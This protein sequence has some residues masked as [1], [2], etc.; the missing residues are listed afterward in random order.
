[1]NIRYQLILILLTPVF[2]WLTLR[3]YFHH[4]DSR[5]LWQR[6]FALKLPTSNHN[7]WFHCASVGEVMTL[8][9]LI[10]VY[11][12][13]FPDHRFLVTTATI[14]GART[15]ENKLP[16]VTHCY[17]PLDYRGNIKRFI[18]A[19]NP[20]SLIIMETE[21]WPN[22]YE[23]SASN[24][25]PIAIINGRLSSRTTESVPW[26]KRI[27]FRALQHVEHIYCRSEEDKKA[28]QQLGAKAHQ[29]EVIGNLKFSARFSS[30]A[31]DDIINIPYV[32]AASTRD[33]EEKRIVELWNKSDHGDL[34]LVIAPRHPE[35]KPQ[36]LDELKHFNENIKVRSLNQEIT[37]DT[38]IYLADTL[39]E[40]P[41]LFSHAA[42]VIMGGSFVNRGGHNILE[43]ANFSKAIL[44]G[45]S[46]HNF[47]SESRLFLQHKAALQAGND[48]AAV[49][50]I[51]QLIIDKGRREE[52][53]KNAHALIVENRDIAERYLDKLAEL[54]E[55]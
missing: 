14:T 21:I 15:C 13:K 52:L 25:I 47:E 44:F 17:L 36:I 38:T 27:F 54:F 16:F 30:S 37:N 31:S 33:H 42:F 19:M 53:G 50:Y 41:A 6:F 48:E 3:H 49:N 22:L 18:D 40:M 35:R 1:M 45:P 34:L 9:P 20:D 43:P 26:S 51:N 55:D 46:M 8:I 5:Y 29:L 24:F 11:H 12:K 7:L 23:L 32:I 10:N 4:K 39:G 2:I 28:F